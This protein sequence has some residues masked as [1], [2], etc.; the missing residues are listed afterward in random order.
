M[1]GFLVFVSI[2]LIHAP[3][4][5]Y[6]GLASVDWG[7]PDRFH[8]VGGSWLA[9]W[10]LHHERPKSFYLFMWRRLPA[11][12]WLINSAISWKEHPVQKHTMEKHTVVKHT[13]KTHR[14][15]TLSRET[16]SGKAHRWRNT[17]RKHTVEKSL[18]LVNVVSF[19]LINITIL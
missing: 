6:A 11:R 17:Q 16:H 19:Q 18:L 4:Y 8:L 3:F 5:I 7:F 1:F 12:S 2:L 13:M 9:C 15:E 10:H 14:G